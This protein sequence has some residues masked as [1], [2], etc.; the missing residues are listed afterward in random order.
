MLTVLC[1]AGAAL[2]MSV[3]GCASILHGTTQTVDITSR[4]PG[5]TARVLPGNTIVTT[6]GS[7]E[8]AR[9]HVHTVRFELPGY[10]RET[11]YVDRMVSSALLGNLIIGGMIGAS[12]DT[13]N[14]AAFFLTPDP[15]DVTLRQPGD[16]V[17]ECDLAPDPQQGAQ[18]AP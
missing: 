1:A 15:V 4:P 6:P 17:L 16:G 9:K 2:I 18:P 3:S 12:I 5:A 13:S 14:G 8:L 11:A 7:L 10:C